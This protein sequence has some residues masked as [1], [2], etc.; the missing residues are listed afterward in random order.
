MYACVN[1]YISVRVWGCVCMHVRVSVFVC[2]QG[3]SQESRDGVWA[4]GS[5]HAQISGERFRLED[6]DTIISPNEEK[7]AEG[8]WA[9]LCLFTGGSFLFSSLAP[10]TSFILLFP[11]SLSFHLV[12]KHCPPTPGQLFA[13]PGLLGQ[14]TCSAFV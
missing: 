12:F 1:V 7:L 3:H 10:K 6:S 2:Y 4:T 14:D 9:L 11:R 5:G 8:L 13:A